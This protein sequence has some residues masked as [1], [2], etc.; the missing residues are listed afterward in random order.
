MSFARDG[1]PAAVPGAD[2]PTRYIGGT[3]A[4]SPAAGPYAVGDFSIDQTG[5][6]W[7][8]TAAGS[9][10]TWVLFL[11]TGGPAAVSSTTVTAASFTNI[12]SGTVAANDAA[13][14]SVYRLAMFGHGT[15]GS[16]Q[17]ALSLQAQI[18]GSTIGSTQ[19]VDAAVFAISAAFRWS[20]ECLLVCVTTGVGGTWAAGWTFTATQTANNVIPGT[21]ANNTVPVA[22]GTS[23]A[24]IADTTIGEAYALQVKW[25]TTTGA[26]TITQDAAWFGRTA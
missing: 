15:W 9:P 4:G 10:G 1:L 19:V 14:G 11:P 5:R 2:W 22:S 26:P 23:S 7:L 17:Q 3:A 24:K 21:A 12:A 13:I 6:I 25:A 8:C 18:G 16:T 20:A